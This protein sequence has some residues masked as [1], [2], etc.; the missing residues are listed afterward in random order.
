MRPPCGLQSALPLSLNVTEVFQSPAVGVL[1]K[2]SKKNK[3]NKSALDATEI[4]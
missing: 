1:L 3:S 4:C 2:S